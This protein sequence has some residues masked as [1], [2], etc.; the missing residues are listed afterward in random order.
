MVKAQLQNG[1]RSADLQGPTRA[2]MEIDS[3]VDAVVGD[4]SSGDRTVEFGYERY[5]KIPG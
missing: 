1:T 3:G 4:D 5:E 2:N